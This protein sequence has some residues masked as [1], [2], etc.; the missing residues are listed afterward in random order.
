[1][2]AV[3]AWEIN[4]NFNFARKVLL[5]VRRKIFLISTRQW[6]FLSFSRALNNSEQ[7]IPTTWHHHLQQQLQPPSCLLSRCS[8][9]LFEISRF[10][11]LYRN[12]DS[13]TFLPAIALIIHLS[14]QSF[15]QHH[16]VQGWSQQM[17]QR[18]AWRD[19]NAEGTEPIEVEE[20]N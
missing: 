1:M 4:F 17:I 19:K 10:C 5:I 6:K 12:W 14:E 7:N 3:Q 8:F 16:W 13:E 11:G 18:R 9:K 15:S 20:A 2:F